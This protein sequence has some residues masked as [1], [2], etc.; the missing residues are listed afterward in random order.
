MRVAPPEDVDR[1]KVTV[2]L[3]DQSPVDLVANNDER[4]NI[5]DQVLKAFPNI[6]NI[7]KVDIMIAMKQ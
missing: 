5:M 7:T 3:L 4:E 1:I 2:S 6:R